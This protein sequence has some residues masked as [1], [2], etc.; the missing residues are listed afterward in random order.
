MPQ[1]DPRDAQIAA[2]REEIVRLRQ[3]LRRADTYVETS[4]RG[5]ECGLHGD[6]QAAL[7]AAPAAKQEVGE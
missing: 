1:T 7:A 3:L 6:I 5:R 2:L 4:R